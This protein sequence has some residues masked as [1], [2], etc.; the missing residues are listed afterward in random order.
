MKERFVKSHDSP[1]TCCCY[2][3]ALKQVI[4]ACEGSVGGTAVACTLRWGEDKLRQSCR[5]LKRPVIAAQY[6]EGK[7]RMLRGISVLRR[8]VHMVYRFQTLYLC[9]LSL[10][11]FRRHY[12]TMLG[13]LC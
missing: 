9:L 2:S 13:S 10:L 6:G 5:S 11:K 3:E 12:L 8:V 7:F 4:T 1:V